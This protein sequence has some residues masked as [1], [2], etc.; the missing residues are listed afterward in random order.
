[1]YQS[2]VAF[3]VAVHLAFIGYLLVGGFLALRWRRTFWL[4]A[5]VVTWAVLIVTAH[6][7]CPLTWLERWARARARMAPLPPDGF[8]AHYL[9]GVLYP[10]SATGPVEFAVLVTVTVSWVLCGRDRLRRRRYGGRYAD[11]DHHR[12][13]ERLL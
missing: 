9:A 11:P 2:A 5:P 12:R 3:I 1:M 6:L 7:D 13:P 4:H 10:A 8:I